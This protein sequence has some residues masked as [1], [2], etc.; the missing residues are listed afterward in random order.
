MEKLAD[1][2]KF[3]RTSRANG[4][5]VREQH[6]Q[7]QSHTIRIHDEVRNSLHTVMQ[8]S[9]EDPIL[10]VL[11]GTSAAVSNALQN[12]EKIKQDYQWQKSNPSNQAGF[13]M[14]A[15]G[16]GNEPAYDIVS[17]RGLPDL[18]GLPG[19]RRLS[20]TAIWDR[21][22]TGFS[23]SASENSYTSMLLKQSVSDQRNMASLPLPS[24][25]GSPELERLGNELDS[26]TSINNTLTAH[27]QGLDY[28]HQPMSLSGE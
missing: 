3:I 17:A 19:S 28:A 2:K 13:T 21:G 5:Q 15:I 7:G 4:R 14:P 6:L 12:M 26:L 10:S 23:D 9:E 24:Q 22:A 20:E 16:V 8:T 27:G 11:Y 25:L 18:P 1:F